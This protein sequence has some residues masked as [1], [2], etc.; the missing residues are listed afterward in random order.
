MVSQKKLV[1]GILFF[2]LVLSFFF[3]LLQPVFLGQ[4]GGTFKTKS[5]PEE[6][7]TFKNFI[8]QQQDF[9]RIFWI[10]NKQRFGFWS[11]KHPGINAEEFFVENA[12]QEPFCLLKK[13]MPKEWGQNCFPNDR[14]YVRELAYFLNPQTEEI[15]S[16]MAVKYVVVPFDSQ[17][18]IF[19]AE[20]K[21]NPQQRTE[22]E[23]LLDSISWLKKVKVADKI[24]V[25]ELPEYKNHF[26]TEPA[27]LAV[28]NSWRMINPTRYLVSLKV[29]KPPVILVFSETY[30]QLWQAKIDGET[31]NSQLFEDLL[32]S[33][34]IKK[35][36][37]LKITVEFSGQKYVYWGGLISII[38]L[39]TTLGA[40]IYFSLRK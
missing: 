27:N 18:E 35:K 17:E 36:G 8:D 34:E 30:D 40:L 26:Y 15:L 29:E 22:V 13:E 2:V 1:L 24:A 7:I 5:L 28:L 12:C 20:R 10:P 14:C 11:D 33:F 6:Y 37:D 31:I 16:K 38:T 19:I 4:L 3:W 23:Q 32:N 9:F 21:Y 25:Y 39:L